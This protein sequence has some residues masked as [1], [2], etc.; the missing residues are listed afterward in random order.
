[1]AAAGANV[2]AL[3]ERLRRLNEEQGGIR[4][5]DSAG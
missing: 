3:G 2:D 1:L 5:D 4:L